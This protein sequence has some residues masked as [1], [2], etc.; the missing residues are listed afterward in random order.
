MRVKMVW[1]VSE[2]LDRVVLGLCTDHVFLVS[3]SLREHGIRVGS[4]LPPQLSHSQRGRESAGNGE[5]QRVRGRD[6]VQ[7]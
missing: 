1:I 2:Q 6:S 7:I 3:R 4:P 5:S